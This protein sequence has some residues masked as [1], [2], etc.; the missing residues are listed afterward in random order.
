MPILYTPY[1]PK[2]EIR[3]CKIERLEVVCTGQSPLQ[4]VGGNK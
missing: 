3:Q 2:G 4:G 1:P